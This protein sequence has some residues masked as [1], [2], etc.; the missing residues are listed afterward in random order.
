MWRLKVS[1]KQVGV[2]WLYIMVVVK[3]SFYIKLHVTY[4]GLNV[5]THD[6]TV[7]KDYWVSDFLTSVLHFFQKIDEEMC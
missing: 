5:S 1:I 4:Y 7:F 6:A 2:C 3:C